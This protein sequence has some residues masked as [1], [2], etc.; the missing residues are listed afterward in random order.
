MIRAKNRCHLLLVSWLIGLISFNCAAS[1]TSP[2]PLEDQIAALNTTRFA[3]KIT[4]VE[5]L[6]A[7]GDSRVVPLLQALLDGRLYVHRDNDKVVIVEKKNQAYL[8]YNPLSL[9]EI[10]QVK[11]RD[12]KKIRI[13]NRL[14]SVIRGALGRL[15]LFHPEVEQRLQAAEAVFK[16]R[17]VDLLPT[18]EKAL[19]RETNEA[20]QR[21]MILALAAIRLSAPA[22]ETRIAAAQTLA[23]YVDPEVRALLSQ[24]LIEQSEGHV[25][26]SNAQV[27]AAIAEAIKNIDDKLA[28]WAF[29]GNLFQGVSLGSVLLLAAIGLAITFG[30]MGVINMAHGEMVML[31]AYTTFLVQELF[32]Q[33]MPTALDY[34]L[35]IAVPAAFVVAGV[36]GILIER[37]IIQ[38]LYGRPLET[39]LATWGVSL[40]LQQSARRLG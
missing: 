37:G 29:V 40:I 13:N 23:G 2:P 12:I 27:R 5:K 11:K 28:V 19:E 7:T 9:E 35:L 16:S 20:V 34:S 39:L 25:V 31:G 26:E 10:E 30:V 22:P 4:A 6:S 32:R 24:F 8:L 18:L 14:R 15:M 21:K 1:A 33:V 3:A 17:P 36:V 38:F